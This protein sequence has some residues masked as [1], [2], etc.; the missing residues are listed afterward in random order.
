MNTKKYLYSGTGYPCA[1]QS[2]DRCSDKDLT[3]QLDFEEDGNVGDL[4]PIGSVLPQKYKV[5]VDK[6]IYLNVGISYPCAKHNKL[7][8]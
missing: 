8:L 5:W 7:I 3:N 1:E 2:K 6:I 4:N